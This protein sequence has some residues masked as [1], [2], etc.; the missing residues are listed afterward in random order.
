MAAVA[1]C[2]GLP[3]GAAGAVTCNFDSLTG[4]LTVTVTNGTLS[5]TISHDTNPS[6]EIKV[7]DDSDFGNG[8]VVCS[9]GTPTDTTTGSIAVDESGSNQATTLRLDFTRGR[10][11]SGTGDTETG[12][13]EIEV[14][15]T[16]DSTGT[17]QFQVNG[18][19]ETA[20]EDFR[21]GAAG[22]VTEGD[23]NGDDDAD[24]V[25]LTGIERIL[26]QPGTGND[27][28]TADGSGS[29]SFTGPSPALITAFASQGD[30]TFASGNGADNRFTGGP[31]DDVVTGGSGADSF[32]MEEGN[33]TFDGAG[34]SADFAS[35]ENTPSATG[36]TLD[37]SQTGPQNTGDLGIDQVA[38]V[39]NAVGS[40]GS[41]HL[42]G[43]GGT[44]TFFGGNISNDAGNDVLNGG[45]GNDQL[46]G[47]SGDDTLI[48]GQGND[49]LEGDAGSDTASYALGSTAAVNIDLGLAKTGVAQSTGGAGTDTLIDG[50]QASDPDP[51]HEVENLIGSPFAGDVLTGNSLANQIDAYDG[52]SDTVDCVDTGD[53]DTAIADEIGVDALTNCE[54]VDNAPQTSIDSG[55]AD[56]ATVTTAT[57]SYG[58]SADEPS[59][60]EV[61]VDSGGF[62]ACSATC[63]VPALTNGPHTLA[64]R[65]VDIDEEGHA[66]LTP[67]VRAVT[68]N[69]QGPP[70]P[71]D[72]TPPETTVFG[73][74]KVKTRKKKARVTWTF[75]STEQGSTF[76]CS[77]DGGAFAPCS[78]PFS[79]KLRRG[80]HTLAVRATDLSGNVDQT[81]TT[82][83]TKV[84]RLRR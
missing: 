73:K 78:S 31:G 45:G 64:F 70:P 22:A 27:V 17:D 83:T 68:V 54:T 15:Y 5:P 32:H 9:G 19:T 52:Q 57:P 40:N 46:I 3:A 34:G 23:L 69:V 28:F 66:D 59:T 13:A 11:G 43:T 51:N 8:T 6:T 65:A 38:N 72:T 49:S 36:V 79:A 55:P 20:A 42:T 56:G 67:A 76:A 77:L 12:V 80:A 7:D 25:V 48:G 37:L 47:W 33:D 75:G 24:D 84:K 21:F 14:A 26:D 81:P 60:F 2:L 29:G 53:G 4:A 44:N 41:D 18:S 71:A 30:D 16:T 50:I 62:Q 82:F 61:N 1:A 35:Y 58:L 10:L 74:S 63:T 39:E